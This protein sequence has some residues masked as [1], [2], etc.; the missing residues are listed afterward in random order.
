MPPK[1]NA[2]QRYM[3]MQL[4]KKRAGKRTDVDMSEDQ[5]RDF[6]T[7][8]GSLE[9][10][11]YHEDAATQDSIDG[12]PLDGS[13]YKHPVH[14]GLKGAD[15]DN[16]GFDTK[17]AVRWGG[18]FFEFDGKVERT[19]ET[20]SGAALRDIGNGV[21]YGAPVDYFGPDTDYRAEELDPH[22]YGR[23]YEPFPFKD[24]YK[25]G[26]KQWERGFRVLAQDEYDQTVTPGTVTDKQPMSEAHG[27]VNYQGAGPDRDVKDY[28]SF[29]SQRK[30]ARTNKD[31]KEPYAV[32]ITG[33]DTK[34]GDD[35][36]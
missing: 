16:P 4:A 14:D 31:A 15:G 27:A 28:R 20:V 36:R 1:S 21:H 33:L 35:I 13:S 5:L 8:G 17:G 34:D 30:Y 22:Q 6:A 12:S 11:T 18:I 25:T 23:S 3:G 32:A 2:Q 26:D 7:K 24:V 10:I 9:D 19:P 29:D